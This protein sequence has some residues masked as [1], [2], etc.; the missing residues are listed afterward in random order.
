[1]DIQKC[2]EITS[3][4]ILSMQGSNYFPKRDWT[5]CFIIERIKSRSPHEYHTLGLT[6]VSKK[7]ILW[8]KDWSSFVSLF[9]SLVRYLFNFSFN[10]MFVSLPYEMYG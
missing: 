7:T 4:V 1:M 3:H 5:V 9:H 2:S 10:R 6:D 8:F